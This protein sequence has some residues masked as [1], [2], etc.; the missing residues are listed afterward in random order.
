MSPVVIGNATLYHGDKRRRSGKAH[1][2]Y[3]GGM[4]HD[5]NGYITFTSGPNKGKREHRLVMEMSL[6]RALRSDEIVHHINGDK[7]D[8]RLENLSL[9]SRASHN[10]E[11]G[12]GRLLTCVKCG[13]EKW[14]S[15]SLAARNNPVNGYKCRACWTADGGNFK[16]T[17]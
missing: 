4:S 10:R 15:P 6:G 2:L 1:P 8:N 9:E 5:G 11:H 17:K 14:Y 16:C 12:K 13:K 7:A 3:R